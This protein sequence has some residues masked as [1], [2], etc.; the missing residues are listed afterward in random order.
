MKRF[1]HVFFGTKRPVLI[2]F[3]AL[4]PGH[5]LPVAEAQ[6]PARAELAGPPHPRH[7]AHSTKPA[8]AT[9]EIVVRF[10]DDKQ[11]EDMVNLFWKDPKAAK[12][13]FDSFKRGRTDLA[14]AALSRATYANELVLA[15]PCSL[16]TAANCQVAAR[17]LAAV[18]RSSADVAY[19]EPDA[20]FRVET[21]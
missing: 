4:L 11:V 13:K 10:R 6:A 17:D 16:P 20:A 9:I 2:A 8:A 5:S 3:A 7:P 18:I 21:P 1:A 12:D 15:F 19:A 14:G